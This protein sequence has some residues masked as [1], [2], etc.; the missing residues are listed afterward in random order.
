MRGSSTGKGP[1]L[2]LGRLEDG[3]QILSRVQQ[4]RFSLD[5]ENP[6]RFSLDKE[7][8]AR[9]SL[10][11]KN[12]ASFCCSAEVK[13]DQKHLLYKSTIVYYRRIYAWAV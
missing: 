13:F 9:F 4:K 2:N 12:L 10:D 6:A 11:K 7:N 5:K 3:Q 8:P 1:R